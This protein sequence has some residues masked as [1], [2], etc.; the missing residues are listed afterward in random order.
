M[1][2]DDGYDEITL[3]SDNNGDDEACPG[4]TGDDGRGRTEAVA[5]MYVWKCSSWSPSLITC[6][7][8]DHLR[9]K[10]NDT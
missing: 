9:P 7:N 10:A 6:L 4:P 2:D 1:N 8:V 5:G 3:V